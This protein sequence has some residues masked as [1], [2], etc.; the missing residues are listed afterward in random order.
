MESSDCISNDIPE[1]SKRFFAQITF[2]PTPNP[3]GIAGQ[4]EHCEVRC[5]LEYLFEFVR[6]EVTLDIS[7]NTSYVWCLS[8]CLSAKHMRYTLA[9][10]RFC[11]HKLRTEGPA[12]PLG[13]VMNIK[14][15]SAS[16]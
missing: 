3:G 11:F 7:H 16:L 13:L 8:V 4:V 9:T 12:I 5:S 1:P 14:P 2:Y 15:I 6:E 10:Q